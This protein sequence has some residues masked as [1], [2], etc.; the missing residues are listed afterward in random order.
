MQGEHN[1]EA[2]LT[3]RVHSLPGGEALTHVAVMEDREK[4]TFVELKNKMVNQSMQLKSVSTLLRFEWQRKRGSW[5][6]QAVEL[7]YDHMRWD[8]DPV[9]KCSL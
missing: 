3:L 2:C 7:Y 9:C 1:E 8:V 4:Q 6:S 5:C